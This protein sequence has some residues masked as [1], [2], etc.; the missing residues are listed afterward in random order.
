MIP[1]GIMVNKWVYNIILFYN[2]C[3]AQVEIHAHNDYEK[4]Y[5]LVNALKHRVFSVEADVFF[6]EH[7][8]YVA[9]DR[10]NV[11]PGKTLNTLYIQPIIALFNQNKGYVSTDTSY[12]FAL[13]IDIKEKGE[14]VIQQLITLLNPYTLQFNRKKNRHAVQII[15]SGDRGPLQK[16]A[17]Y[18]EYLYFDGRPY[19]EYDALMLQRI[20]MIS[21]SYTR[22][23]NSIDKRTLVINKVH[24]QGKP[25]RFWG[26][27][28]NKQT[29]NLLHSLGVDIINTDHVEE[30]SRFFREMNALK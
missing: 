21:D 18:P 15:I 5:P 28:D 12:Q 25:F 9:H 23:A 3:F 22:Y 4:P 29:W 26:A 2:T 1:F 8:L 10:V 20:A 7:D 16:W 24:E 6:G 30:C 13:V 14:Q 17:D 19:E 27:P 11:N